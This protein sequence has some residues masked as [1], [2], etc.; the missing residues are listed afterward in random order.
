MK[1]VLELSI[2][3]T[4][5]PLQAQDKKEKQSY[6]TE[7]VIEGLGEA[8]E[9][10]FH[11]VVVFVVGS[12]SQSGSRTRRSAATAFSWSEARGCGVVTNCQVR[13]SGATARE[14]RQFGKKVELRRSP[15]S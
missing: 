14:A 5:R 11:F 15:S 10:S 6:T 3:G 7:T 2:P 8:S 12:S 13:G 9:R 4:A 1:S